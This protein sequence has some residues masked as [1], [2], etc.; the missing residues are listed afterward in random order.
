M[1][2]ETY[3]NAGVDIEEGERAV[4]EI[5]SMVRTT[6][7]KNVLTDLGSFGGMFLFNK[8]EYNEPVLVSSTDGVG[9]KLKVAFMMDKHDTVGED[10]VNHCVNDIAVG[11]AKPLF[12]LDYFATEKL[13]SHVFKDVISGFVRGCKNNNCALIGGETAEMPDMYITGEYDLSGTIVGVVDKSKA[14]T[15]N[16]IKKSD[17]MLGLAS[18][19]LHTNGYSLARRVLLKDHDINDHIDELGYTIGEELLRVHL[20]YLDIIQF[21][22]QNFPVVGISHI[23]GGGIAG[24]TKRIISDTLDLSIDWSSWEVPPIF[25]LIK[26]WGNVPEEDMRS[27]FNLGIGLVMIVPKEYAQGFYDFLN[28]NGYKSYFIGEIV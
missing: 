2:V 17:I 11:G 22:V 24:N 8:D 28:Q 18:N 19:G 6:H 20:C 7:S 25:S 21:A 4:Q 10:L 16:Q 14:I 23:T 13:N 5:K 27:A 9:T 1:P 3:K 12:F 26:D 15:G